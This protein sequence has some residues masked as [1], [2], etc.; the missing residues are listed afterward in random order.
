MRFDTGAESVRIDMRYLRF[1]PCGAREGGDSQIKAGVQATKKKLTETGEYFF[2]QS[3]IDFVFLLTNQN[4]SR[5][6]CNYFS[7]PTVATG[8]SIW[9]VLASVLCS[10]ISFAFSSKSVCKMSV[11]DIYYSSKIPDDEG[12]EIR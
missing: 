2:D 11:K 8:I 5:T 10:F 4:K 6:F 7:S 3:E 12:N 9:Y 1:M